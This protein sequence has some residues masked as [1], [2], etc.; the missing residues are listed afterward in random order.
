[1]QA[2]PVVDNTIAQQ[3]SQAGPLFKEPGLGGNQS[4]PDLGGNKLSFCIQYINVLFLIF[5]LGFIS[6]LFH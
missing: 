1:M 2:M 4:L 3:C 6:P 5:L